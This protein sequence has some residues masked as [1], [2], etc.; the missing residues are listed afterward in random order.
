MKKIGMVVAVEMEALLSRY[1]EP[2]ERINS[3]GFPVLVYGFEGYELYVLNSGAGEIASSAG[4]QVLISVFGV[5]M[6]VNYGVVGGLT[7]EMEKTSTC[8]VESV[9]HYDFDTHEWDNCVPGQ[10]IMY[11]SPFIPTTAEL[12]QKA[13][14]VMPELKGVVCASGDKFVGSAEAKRELNARFGA[15]ICEMEAAGIVLTCNRCGVPCLL[16][17]TVSD[18]LTGGAEEFS[19]ELERASGICLEIAGSIMEQL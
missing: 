10:Y 17:K 19:Q 11:P 6:I 4:T 13:K 16:I 15:E 1:G 18:S 2:R 8:V 5:D 3:F 12:V 14:A 9:V 7:A